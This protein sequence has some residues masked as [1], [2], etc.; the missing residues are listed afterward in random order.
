[1]RMT[2][3]KL[4]GHAKVYPFLLKIPECSTML[5]NYEFII[6]LVRPFCDAYIF[7]KK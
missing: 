2:I 3:A 6:M 1:M 7:Y 5:I 4:Y